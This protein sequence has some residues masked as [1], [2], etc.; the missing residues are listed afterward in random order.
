MPRPEPLFP[1]RTGLPSKN[2]SSFHRVSNPG[3]LQASQG[4]SMPL[5]CVYRNGK[6]L[7]I[8]TFLSQKECVNGERARSLEAGRSLIYMICTIYQCIMTARRDLYVTAPVHMLAGWGLC[9]TAL[10]QHLMTANIQS[11]GSRS[12]CICPM[13]RSLPISLDTSSLVPSTYVLFCVPR[14]ET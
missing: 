11:R 7:G 9:D 13:C 6:S 5:T 2:T 14:V 8:Y 10:P 4:N 3:T 1:V 12:G